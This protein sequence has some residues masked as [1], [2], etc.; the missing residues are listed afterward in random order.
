MLTSAWHL[1]SLRRNAKATIRVPLAAVREN[2]TVQS[3]NPR[4]FGR[5]TWTLA[6]A[7]VVCL[8]F[9]H[10]SRAQ[11]DGLARGK[12]GSCDPD[13]PPRLAGFHL[14]QRRV[15]P[16][17]NLRWEQ[18]ACDPR[19]AAAAETANPAQSGCPVFPGGRRDAGQRHAAVA[20][21]SDQWVYWPRSLRFTVPGWRPFRLPR[22]LAAR[23]PRWRRGPGTVR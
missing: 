16:G 21:M 15:G 7:Y 5:M 1:S 6:R 11:Q 19:S 10:F 9:F 8:R 22:L 12:A 23:R 18:F 20:R 14:P 2:S 4:E 17:A 3:P 13:R